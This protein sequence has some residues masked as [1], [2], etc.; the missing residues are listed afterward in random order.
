[1]G[2]FTEVKLKKL[3]STQFADIYQGLSTNFYEVKEAILSEKEK[4]F[5]NFL[6]KEIH[7]G[8]SLK[9][10]FEGVDDSALELFSDEVVSVIELNEL[11][12]KLPSKSMLVSLLESL[13][14]VVSKVRF[15]SDKALFAEF[16]LQNSVGLRQL[17]F[18]SFDDDLEELMI[19]NPQSVFVFHKKYGMCKTN[20]SIEG[21]V[22]LNI[23]DRIALTIGREFNPKNALLDARLPDGSRVNATL[24]DI[25]PTGAT[26]TIRKFSAIPLTILDLIQNGTVTSEAAAFLWLMVDGL[27]VYPQ[28]ILVAGGTASGKT[29]FLNILSN[30]IRLNERVV[31]I[32]DTIELSLLGRENWVALEARSSV[33]SE[34]PMD[35]LLKNSMRMRPD[36]IIVGEVRGS[37]ALTLFT[38][39]DTG[40]QGILGTI[41]ANNARETI[42]KLQERPLSVPQ[43]MLPLL[44][45][46]VVMER[47][48]SPETG[49]VRRVT[50]IVELSRME[51]KVLFGSLFEFDD[52]SG[53]LKRTDISSSILEEVAQK[54]SLIKNELK[55]EIEVRRTVLE[56]MIR[57]GIRK[58]L[59]VLEVIESYYYNPEK[60][61]ST[62]S[63]LQ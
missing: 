40:H 46:V 35:A 28:N 56:W 16:V 58:P 13:V 5:A 42:I 38:A 9:K 55:K 53:S 18:F 14:K 17:A 47:H 8:S 43:A 33:G 32:E 22:L 29:T 2:S 57:Q 30:F 54:N 20:I 23:I 44:D 36:R 15:V 45:F 52:K 1:M 41:H 51:Q 3:E 62:I 24:A 59:E 61:L 6:I 21:N 31:S 26:L 19:N 34:V 39:M 50:Q 63:E 25:S 7:K 27:G 12:D 37:E 4:N 48:Y 10:G 11:L 49:M 60:V